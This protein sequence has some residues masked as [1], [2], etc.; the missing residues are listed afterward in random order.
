MLGIQDLTTG[1]STSGMQAYREE[2][3]SSLLLS[4]QEKLRS[5]QEVETALNEGWQGTA[6][7]RFKTQMNATVE[8]ICEDL[9][10]EYA[11]LENRLIDLESAYF[12]ADNILME[13]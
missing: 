6:A 7:D 3:K 1:I 4:S 2:L 9:Q 5:L 8:K 11:D 10:K 12:N 13:E